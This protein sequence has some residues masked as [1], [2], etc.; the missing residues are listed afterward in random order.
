[1]SE[2]RDAFAAR[3]NGRRYLNEISLAEEEEAKGA[4]LLVVFGASSDLTEFPDTF[5]RVF[6]IILSL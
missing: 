5:C 3:L 4:H 1:M 2:A 6:H